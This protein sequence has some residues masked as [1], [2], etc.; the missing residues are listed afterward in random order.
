M[1]LERSRRIEKLSVG[2]FVGWSPRSIELA[3]ASQVVPPIAQVDRAS[4][5]EPGRS[6]NRPGRSSQPGRARSL[7]QLPRTME[8]ARAEICLFTF[9]FDKTSQHGKAPQ[10]L[11]RRRSPNYPMKG[12]LRDRPDEPVGSRMVAPLQRVKLVR[13]MPGAMHSAERT[14]EVSRFET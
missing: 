2:A 1:Q 11:A 12:R 10:S 5:G 7:S 6:A 3:T 4:Q 14:F 13:A 9:L 8:P